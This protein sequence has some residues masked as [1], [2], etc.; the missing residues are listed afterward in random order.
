MHFADVAAPQELV[1]RLSAEMKINT[2]FNSPTFSQGVA[3][4]AGADQLKEFVAQ[5]GRELTEYDPRLIAVIPKSATVRGNLQSL[6]ATLNDLETFLTK[7]A[8][9][10]VLF[11]SSTKYRAKIANFLH[12]LRSKSTQLLTSITLELLTSQQQ[13]QSPRAPRTQGESSP[14]ETE[15]SPVDEVT[16]T[17]P[18]DEEPFSPQATSVPPP[19]SIAEATALLSP[20]EGNQQTTLNG[21]ASFYGIPP[22]VKNYTVAAEAFAVAATGGDGDAML[23][24]SECYE[25]GW[26]VEQDTP[27]STSWLEKAVAAGSR[28]AMHRNAMQVRTAPVALSAWMCPRPTPPLPPAA[29]PAR[30][31]PC[32]C[33]RLWTSTM[34]RICAPFSG[35]SLT[36][37]KTASPW[38]LP[39]CQ[40]PWRWIPRAPGGA[41]A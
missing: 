39:R 23:M 16:K 30:Q 40:H 21:T 10:K 12:L 1:K 37:H 4:D 9:K 29:L 38:P 27:V 5:L 13:P 20:T 24:L 22:L 31:R 19:T 14:H 18:V 28:A 2:N 41:A 32:R 25:H 26:G 35:I 15:R 3:K 8:A 17:V 34:Q 36:G 6:T 7:L 33:S 11:F